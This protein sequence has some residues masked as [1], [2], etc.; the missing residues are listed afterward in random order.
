MA[1]IIKDSELQEAHLTEDELRLEIAIML[2]QQGR[3]SMGRASK[4]ADMNRILLIKKLG[5]RQ[6]PINYDED[7][8]EEDLKTL[9][10]QLDD[11][12]K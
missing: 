6:I 9:G 5:R 8:L 3:L 11:R 1:L 4:F 2:Y 10:I 7:E 12:S